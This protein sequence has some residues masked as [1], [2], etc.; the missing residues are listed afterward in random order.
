MLIAHDLGTT[1]NK[2]TLVDNSGT[3][4]ASKTIAYGADWGTDGKAEQNAHDWWDAVCRAIRELLAETNT[5]AAEIE[6]ISFSGQMMGAV[7]LDAAGEPVRPAQR[8]RRQVLQQ[9]AASDPE[10]GPYRHDHP[11]LPARRQLAG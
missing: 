10:P 6:G 3:M 2:A 11:Q 1:G 8:L 9:Q 5:P 7:P 4:L